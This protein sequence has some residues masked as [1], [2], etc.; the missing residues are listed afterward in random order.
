MISSFFFVAVN[1]TPNPENKNLRL[2][3]ISCHLILFLSILYLNDIFLDNKEIIDRL[4]LP[5]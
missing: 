1:F 5:F 3:I 4:S 2:N